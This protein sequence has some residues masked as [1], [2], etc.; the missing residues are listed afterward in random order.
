M[1]YDINEKQAYAL[2]KFVK[3][4]RCYLVGA[5]VIAFVSNVAVKDIFSQQEVSDRR[6]RWI[7]RIQ[8]FNIDIQI[9]KL[10]RGQGLA[11]L[12][13]QANLDANQI[14][15]QDQ[16][17]SLSTCDMENCDWY[18]DIIYYLHHMQSPPHLTENEKRT[19]KLHSVRYII[20]NGI[21]WWRNFEGILLKCI[22]QQN[23]EKILREMHSGVSGGHYMA[24]TIA[25]KVM[26]VG[27][28]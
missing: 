5:I 13:A 15:A 21:L 20:V 26:R 28:F 11:K 19:I 3:A 24:K 18:K 1:K 9:T 25:H 4:F 7:N 22:D 12:M 14:N 17:L 23:S 27:F 2:V 6:C 16:N 8:E 10:V